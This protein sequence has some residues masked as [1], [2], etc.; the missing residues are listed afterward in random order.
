ME[1]TVTLS[2]KKLHRARRP[3]KQADALARGGVEEYI[4]VFGKNPV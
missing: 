1:S 4:N 2:H 3:L